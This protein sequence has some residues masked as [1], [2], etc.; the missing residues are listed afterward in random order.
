MC[1]RTALTCQGPDHTNISL[2]SLTGDS[3][4]YTLCPWAGSS[5]KPLAWAPR[6]V[7][8]FPALSP[9]DLAFC[10][11]SRGG[12]CTYPCHQP[13][14]QSSLLLLPIRLLGESQDMTHCLI[15]GIVPWS[16]RAMSCL[17]FSSCGLQQPCPCSSQQENSGEE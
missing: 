8:L 13:Y 15:C 5:T 16:A 17:C 10:L 3:H 11:L 9:P 12:L 1:R 7:P 4:P 14:L 2:K 6:A